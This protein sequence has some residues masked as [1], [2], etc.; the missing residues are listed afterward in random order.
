MFVVGKYKSFYDAI[1]KEEW[2][3]M[4]LWQSF[5]V[6]RILFLKLEWFIG[7]W[8][9]LYGWCS[10]E[11]YLE[12]EFLKT[13]IMLWSIFRHEQSAE[14]EREREN[15]LWNLDGTSTK[16]FLA[17]STRPLLIGYT[18]VPRVAL[19]RKIAISP[20]KWTI[21]CSCP[22]TYIYTFYPLKIHYISSSDHIF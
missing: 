6:Y 4:P 15:W 22:P 1:V 21:W 12:G 18:I 20:C 3:W 5:C 13:Q 19:L 2:N 17:N 7:Y 14:R 9:L 11:A 16:V 8:K 10:Y